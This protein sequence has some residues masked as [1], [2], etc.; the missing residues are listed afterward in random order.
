[1]MKVCGGNVCED[2]VVEISLHTSHSIEK[3]EYGSSVGSH[4]LQIFCRV[5]CAAVGIKTLALD[6]HHGVPDVD[7]ARHKSNRQ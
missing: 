7:G 1:M 2:V 5:F 4:R 3:S 6:D